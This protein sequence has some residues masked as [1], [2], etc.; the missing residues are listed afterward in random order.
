M[1]LLKIPTIKF[2]F[3]KVSSLFFLFTKTLLW[4]DPLDLNSNYLISAGFNDLNAP[5]VSQ[6]AAINFKFL[7]L[8][9][10]GSDCSSTDPAERKMKLFTKNRCYIPV[11]KALRLH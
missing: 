4:S 6:L 5:V 11:L 7:F 9:L 8:S 10:T 1:E 2:H 3:R